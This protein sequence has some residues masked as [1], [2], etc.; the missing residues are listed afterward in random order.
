MNFKKNNP[1]LASTLHITLSLVLIL[2]AAVLMASSF[3][4]A[5]SSS[6]QREDPASSS[7]FANVTGP[8]GVAAA[9]GKL[10]VSEYC[11]G[12]LDAIDDLGNVTPFA[13]IPNYPGGCNEIYLA[14][15][16]GF[17]TWAPNDI[18]ATLGDKI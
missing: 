8:V 11:T 14:I 1:A 10:I 7:V 18:Y 5:Q 12:N 17:G 9:P 2:S 4:S 15:S 13:S 6:P 16:P 3:K